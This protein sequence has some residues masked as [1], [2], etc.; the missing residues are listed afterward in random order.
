MTDQEK[1]DLAEPTWH[2]V[3]SQ[4]RV[5]LGVFGSALLADAQECARRT[6]RDTGFPAFVHQVSGERPNVGGVLP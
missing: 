3:A 1:A 4:G 2:V 5:I 6:E